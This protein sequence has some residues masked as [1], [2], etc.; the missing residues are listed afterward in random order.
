[1]QFDRR[2]FLWG[3]GAVGL[4]LAAPSLAG[5]GARPPV[6]R[7]GPFRHGVASGDPD[8]GSVLLWTRVDG[9]APGAAAEVTWEVSTR[10]DLATTVATGRTVASADR[11]G[12]VTVTAAGLGP[13]TTYYYRFSTGGSVSPVGRTRTTPSGPTARLRLGVV[14]CSNY[15]FGNFHLYGYLAERADL[16][17]IVHL[18]D[19]TYEYATAGAGETYGEYRTLEP[20]NETRTLADYRT[21]YSHYRLDPDLQ[22]LHRQHPVIHCWDD[23]EFA[24]DPF[25]GGAANHQPEDGDWEARKAAALQAYSEWMP[26]RL[27]GNEIHRSVDFGDLARLV[28][29]DRQRKYLFPGPADGDGYLDEPQFSWLDGRLRSTSSRWCVLGQGSVFGSRS[30]DMAGG[31][32]G[33][34]SRNRVHGAL[35]G[36]TGPGGRPDLVVIGGDIHQ[37]NAMDL[38]RVPGVYDPVT[39]AGSAGVELECGSITSSGSDSPISS[40]QERWNIGSYRTYLL[41]DLTPE[42]VQ[43]DFWGFPDTAKLLQRA[44]GHEWLTGWVSPR[45]ASH[46]TAVSAAAPDRADAP[47]PAP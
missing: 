37:A 45:G 33:V 35:D 32:W 7:E 40:L 9:L 8:A 3:T 43:A 6:D 11:D 42:R 15:A 18:G 46:L 47:L 19:Y 5:C 2:T 29:V 27:R 1:M 44:N 34:A 22:E 12:C 28:L 31:G 21:R 23:H 4:A 17:A 25:V 16:D 13:S 30:R 39:G 20:P 10:P 36:A 41:L 14:S 38:P 26:S 24:D